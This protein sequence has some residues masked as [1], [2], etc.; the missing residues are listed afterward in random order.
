MS[1]RNIA[2]Y[3]TFNSLFLN[4][5]D[6]Q[7]N[8]VGLSIYPYNSTI[9]AYT[10]NPNTKIATFD[11][12]INVSGTAMFN[13]IAITEYEGGVFNLSTDNTGDTIDIGF[14][15]KYLNGTDKFTGIIRDSSDIYKRFVFFEEIDTQPGDTVETID[16]TKLSGVKAKSIHVNSGTELLASIAFD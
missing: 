15:G 13:T 8:E 4:K 1:R 11:G 5:L 3:S 16:S 12:D 6:I 10:F 9:P 2:N 14:S 7:T